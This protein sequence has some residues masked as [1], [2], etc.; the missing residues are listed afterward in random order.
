MWLVSRITFCYRDNLETRD[1]FT[2]HKPNQLHTLLP[3][4]PAC[5][6]QNVARFSRGKSSKVQSLSVNSWTHAC[7]HA[8]GTSEDFLRR[9]TPFIRFL[10]HTY[11]YEWKGF[12]C[13]IPPAAFSV[14]LNVM[15]VKF[16]L[17]NH[18]Y[19]IRVFILNFT[20]RKE[21]RSSSWFH[22]TF[23]WNKR[24]SGRYYCGSFVHRDILK[25]G[26]MYIISGLRLT[27][28]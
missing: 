9:I 5:N 14:R 3:K 26:I 17:W 18:F 11:I 1:I 19:V 27:F 20:A 15:V 23:I 4:S 28:G 25:E 10:Y 12:L 13:G 22:L 2:L 21:A 8:Q 6:F 24:E 16:K 7:G